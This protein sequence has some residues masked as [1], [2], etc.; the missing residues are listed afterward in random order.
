MS[1]IGERVTVASSHFQW[2]AIF[3][4]AA[5]AAGTS[6]TLN[7]FGAGI[8][9]S[10]VSGTWRESS[11]VAWL[12]AGVFLL[13]VAIVSF[14]VGGYVAGRM[15]APLNIDA[16][17]SEFRDGMHGLATW[18]LAILLGALL[19]LGAAAAS[20]SAPSNTSG[21]QT[22]TGE[23]IIASELD[24]MFRTDRV[25]DDL[26][27]RR[28]EAAR[29]LLTSTGHNGVSNPDRRYLTTITGI[30]IGAPETEAKAR[31]DHAIEASAQALH[32]ARVA[33][34]LQAFFVAAALFVGAAIAWHAAAEG[35]KDREQ[36]AYHFWNFHGRRRI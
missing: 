30:I 9:L 22:A 12:V 19:A 27:F 36:G 17:E 18:G 29:I 20:A 1:A 32:R 28:A 8:G 6:L 34:V 14:A 16:A 13:F 21:T 33:A 35:G 11:A 31:V 4:G 15:R 7:A 26:S 5:V 2:P 23:S 24:E 25:I 10:V 3:G